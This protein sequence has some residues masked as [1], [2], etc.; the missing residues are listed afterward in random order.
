M[1]LLFLS[2]MLMFQLVDGP[3]DEVLGVVDGDRRRES[4]P[5]HVWLEPAPGPEVPLRRHPPPSNQVL[6][7]ACSVNGESW[8]IKQIGYWLKI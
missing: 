4:P 7:G 6:R 2:E 8:E 5:G 3:E 1:P